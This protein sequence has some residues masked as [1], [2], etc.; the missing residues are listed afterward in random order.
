MEAQKVRKYVIAAALWVAVPATVGAAGAK[1]PPNLARA[2]AAYDRAQIEGDRAALERLLADDYRLVNSGAEVETKAQFVAESSDP[3]FKL[4]PFV[5]TAPIQTVWSNGAV[6]AGEV[7]LKGMSAGKPF[8]AR[9]R[10][11]DVWAMRN[12]RWQVV[13]TEVTRV[14]ERRP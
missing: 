3:T 11:A 4:D 5:V 2:A 10:F 14:P 7:H 9:L 8:A 12:G 13:F 1:L 6:L